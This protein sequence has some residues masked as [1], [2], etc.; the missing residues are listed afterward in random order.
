MKFLHRILLLTCAGVALAAT[1][2]SKSALDQA[3]GKGTIKAIHASTGLGPVQF[4]IEER[5]LS[6]I[7]YREVLAGSRFDDLSYAFHFDAQSPV[8][9]TITR[10]ASRTLDVQ[11]GTDYTFVLTGPADNATVTLWERPEKNWVGD[12]AQFAISFGNVAEN[13]GDLDFYFA[14]PGTAPVDGNQLAR[15]AFGERAPELELAA[16]DYELIITAAG[17]P[18]AVHFQ[19]N[20]TTQNGG[21]NLLF[22]AFDAAGLATSPL[23]VQSVSGAGNLPV[24]DAN[25]DSQLRAVHSVLGLGNVDIYLAQDFTTKFLP[26][27]GFT[28]ITPFKAF[29]GSDL[30]ISVTP[31]DNVGVITAEQIFSV[32]YNAAFTTFILGTTADP[33][34]SLFR[35]NERTLDDVGT[36]KVMQGSENHATLDL[37]IKTT[38]TDITEVSPS[39]VG[40]PSRTMS[41]EIFLAPGSYEITLTVKDEKTVVAGPFPLEVAGDSL[42]EILIVDTVDPA[43]A[44]FVVITDVVN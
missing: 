25:T 41:N 10:I 24:T 39:I 12:E 29:T 21:R 17:N 13:W 23:I 31:L 18:A 5:L 22:V 20:V 11:A 26:D 38:G 14:P 32:A 27:I 44:D 43:T 8:D 33:I 3:T 16:G 37:Y 42:Q 9:G 36:L 40:Q 4:R 15:L 6:T 34:I 7:N 30:N 28:D 19:S 35:S 1:G 2:C